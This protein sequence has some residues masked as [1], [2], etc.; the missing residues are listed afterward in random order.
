MY[1]FRLSVHLRNLGFSEEYS[2]FLLKKWSQ[3]NRPVNGKQIITEEEI[4][5]QT[6][7]AYKKEYSSLGCDTPEMQIYC[8][9]DC[10]IL[11]RRSKQADSENNRKGG[12]TI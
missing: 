5:D 6:S 3:K 2:V 8:V 10:R 9:P 7:S 12:E 4:E 11:K 1:C